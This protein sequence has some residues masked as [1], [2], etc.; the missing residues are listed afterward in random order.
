MKKKLLPFVLLFLILKGFANPIVPP[1]IISEIYLNGNTIQIEFYFV[2]WLDYENFDNLY[3][4][5]SIDTV[6]FLDGIEII[7]NEIIVLD[8]DDLVGIFEYIPEG[9]QIYIIDYD[10]YESWHIRFG[11]F[12]GAAVPAPNE[13]QSIAFHDF[14]YPWPPVHD[15]WICLE[16][17]PT[18]GS[19]SFNVT[20]RGM[21]E[22]YI[23][24]LNNNPVPDVHINYPYTDITINW[25]VNTDSAG[26][27]LMPNLI[28]RNYN[29]INFSISGYSDSFSVTVLPDETSYVEIQLDTFFVGIPEYYNYPNPFSGS[30]SFSIQ[31]PKETNFNTGR[32]SIYN[33]SGKLVDRIEIPSNDY[34]A[35]WQSNNL[36]PGIY[37]Y[38]I[39]LDNKKFATKKMLIL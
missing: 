34:T 33:V 31:I 9:D 38:N 8:Q 16:Q 27:F 5:S 37:L 21:I 26:I 20:A 11:N 12:P 23:Y 22:G 36:E 4:V 10:Y 2:D 1:P 28:C 18:I 39:V 14:F 6:G 30:T 24:D 25:N 13:N 17:P 3:L 29:S 32:L 7:P 19:D 15:Y 35:E